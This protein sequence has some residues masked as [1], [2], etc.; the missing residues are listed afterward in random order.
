M[1]V[2]SFIP[3]TDAKKTVE[4]KVKEKLSTDELTTIESPGKP[5]PASNLEEKST[6]KITKGKRKSRKAKAKET[7]VKITSPKKD[8]ILIITEKP[9]SAFK[10]ASA[11]GT[12]RKYS[13]NNAPFYELRRGNDKIIVASA[14]GHLFNLTYSKGQTGW[15]IFKT[16]WVP[17]YNSKGAAFTKN[18]YNLLK[19]LAKRAKEVIIATDYDIEGEVI[20]WNVLRFIVKKDKAKR[21]KYSTLTKNELEK[22]YEKPL[23]TLDWGQAYAGETRHLI[24]WLYGINLSRAL[25][26]AIKRTGSFKILSIGRVQGPTLKIIVE[27]DKEIA[28]FKSV[29]YWQV[30]ALCQG[31]QFKHP[32]DIFNKKELSHFKDIKEAIAKTIKKEENIQPPHPFDL[33]T[34]Q[35]EAHAHHRISPSN[36]LRLAQS[37]YLNGLISYPRTSSQKIPKEI[38]PKKILEKLKERFSEEVKIAS[39]KLPVE[40]KK[41]D[42]AHPSIYPTGEFKSLQDDDEKI[43][44]LIVRRFISAFSPDAKTSNKKIT[45]TPTN[46]SDKKFTASGLTV[47]EKG[48]TKVYPTKFEEK[49]LPNIDG[50]VKIDKIEFLEKE[51]QP[52]KRYTP[53]SLISLLEKRNLGTKGTRS[54]IVDTLFDRDYLDGKSIQATPLGM[55]LIEAMEKYSPI[56]IDE[57]LTRNVEEKMEE[58][59]KS[60]E[61]FSQKEEQIIKNVEK[62]ITDISKDFKAHELD[63]G[64]ELLKGTEQLRE[65]QKQ[66]NTLMQCPVCKLGSSTIKYSKKTKRYFVACDRYP[67]CTA[68]YSLPP[69]A[70]IKKTEKVNEEGLPILMAIRKGKRPWE[71][72]FDPNWREKQDKKKKEEEEKVS[73]N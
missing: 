53:A 72:P 6:K 31:V 35:R 5:V 69:N 56:I 43:Y 32:K 8:S 22:A 63:I 18:Y 17:S 28:N 62:I 39:R 4:K 1:P 25:M 14:V 70:L 55:K 19:K 48:W 41:T 10:I 15:P 23:A 26:S 61:N 71:F 13:E 30:I 52:P 42:P 36:T 45:L 57:S 59:L 16:E 54:M 2:E 73:D 47:L 49:S 21:M 11:L 65:L 27:R 3:A 67:E 24:D 9:Q 68:T 40:G 46:M 38:D 34:L 44:E 58:I 60:K 33:T 50:K 29:P 7:E 64:K 37:L 12:A 20:G 51:T 66:N